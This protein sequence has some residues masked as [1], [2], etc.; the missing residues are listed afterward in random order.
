MINVEFN[1]R[2]IITPMQCFENDI[3][4]DICKKFAMKL[5]MNL[6]NIYFLYSGTN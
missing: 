6:D 2:G 3:I 1:Y 4:G 5:K